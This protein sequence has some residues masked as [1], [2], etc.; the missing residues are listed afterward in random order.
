MPSSNPMFITECATSCTRMLSDLWV[1]QGRN[2]TFSSAQQHVGFPLLPPYPRAVAASQP[3]WLNHRPLREIQTELFKE[4]SQLKRW[5]TTSDRN[6][7]THSKSCWY[8]EKTKQNTRPKG[9]PGTT[10]C[11]EGASAPV[12]ST[13]DSYTHQDHVYWENSY[14]ASHWQ[15]HLHC[16][17][18][19][20][21]QGCRLWLDS[22]Q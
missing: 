12:A 2:N 9:H 19:A 10:P 20:R 8:S 6:L 4:K 15:A 14:W 11:R 21:R 1:L 18:A 3:P 13:A 22:F 16:I 7:S 5:T 17:C